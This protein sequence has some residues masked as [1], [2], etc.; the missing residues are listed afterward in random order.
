MI[1]LTKPP[2]CILGKFTV[3][4]YYNYYNYYYCYD[5]LDNRDSIPGKNSVFFSSSPHCHRR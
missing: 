4:L 3:V 2:G 5:G 1:F